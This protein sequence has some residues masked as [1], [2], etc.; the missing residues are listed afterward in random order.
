M[1]YSCSIWLTLED[2]LETAQRQKVHTIIRRADINTH[3]HI[4]D[5]GG[6]W[7]FLALE[8]FR[9][10]GCRVTAITLSKE[11]KDLAEQLVKAE[12]LGDHI[13]FLLCDYRKCPKPLGGYDRIISVEMIE[14]VRREFLDGYFEVL[15]SLLNPTDGKIVVQSSTFCEEVSLSSILGFLEASMAKRSSGLTLEI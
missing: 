11:Q 14:H 3:H 15:N 2:S 5:I 6:G 12:S 10:T 1:C 8:A 4:L 9:L 13:S 7:G